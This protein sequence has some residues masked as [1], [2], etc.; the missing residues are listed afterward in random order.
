[1]SHGQTSDWIRRREAAALL[2]VPLPNLTPIAR[3]NGVR[4]LQ[5]AGSRPKY[6][7]SDCIRLKESS[8][9]NGPPAMA[10]AK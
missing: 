6:S 9:V 1:M 8:I 10:E 2:E 7:R 3:R 5:I 4:I